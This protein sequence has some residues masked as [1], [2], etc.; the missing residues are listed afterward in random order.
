VKLATERFLLV[1]LNPARYVEPASIGGG[2]YEINLPFLINKMQRNGV[3]LTQDAVA[4]T[5]NDHWHQDD[6]TLTLQVKLAS[7]P[8]ED[9]N[10]IVVFHY[11][12]YT[13]TS[14]RVISEDPTDDATELREWEPRIAQY[15]TFG[16]SFAN[17]LQGV[18]TIGDIDVTLINPD[19]DFQELLSEDDSFFN[20]AVDVWFCIKDVTNIKRIFSGTIKKIN[21]TQN[22]AIVTC[23]DSF[24]KLVQPALMGD[25]QSDAYAAKATWA[26]IDP[27]KKDY[28]LPYIVGPFSRYVTA[29]ATESISTLKLI[30][31]MI[32]GNRA[33]DISYARPP[34]TSNNRTW[35]ACRQKSVVAT[36]SFGT[37]DTVLTVGAY[38]FVKFSTISNAMVGDVLKYV[39][40]AVTYYGHIRYV[41]DFTYLSN[42]YNCIVETAALTTSSTVA[43]SKSFAVTVAGLGGEDRYSCLYDRD[44]TVDDSTTT[45]GG[46]VV[47]KFTF[48]NNF[49]ATVGMATPLDSITF[50]VFYRS[51][52][53]SPESHGQI[54]KDF[55][56][57]VGIPYS[58]ATF[59]AAD[60]A[61][62]TK[63]AFSI[64]NFDEIDYDYY[65]KYVQDVLGS[66]LGFLRINDAFEA[67]YYLLEPPTSTDVRDSSLL[68]RDTTQCDIEYQD[69]V[70]TLIAYNP[71]NSS[72]FET[73][74]AS[75]PSETRSSAKSQYLNGLENVNRFRHVLQY[76]TDR[77][78]AHIGIKSTRFA[79]YRLETATQDIDSELGDDL[80]LDNKITLGGSTVQ[81]VKI[82][83]VNKSPGKIAIEAS[84]LKG[85]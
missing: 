23:A 58:A 48:T 43:N 47:V 17:I 8:D 78:D 59:T 66:T 22:T 75:T 56:D 36:Q 41:G 65:L 44:F 80:Q 45:S 82:I 57:Q 12:F 63:A 1:R 70:T 74:K 71:H 2:I 79:K 31:S 40:S 67:E 3:D 83:S 76:M 53:S 16:Q 24:N 81:D 9:T 49:E 32:E 85:L 84:D 6:T 5:V 61:L 42:P 26:D 11:L 33:L 29:L 30:Y 34:T 51:T 35:I 21:L 10:V 55:L 68:L 20:K 38:K 50:D 19:R 73:S 72:E 14:Y 62:V 15:P 18:F 28:P 25:S 7:A 60:A 54:L 4:P 27:G 39:E 64:P 77:I 69:I 37:L 52:N 46:N 13:G